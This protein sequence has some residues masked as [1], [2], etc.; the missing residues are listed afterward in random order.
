MQLYCSD[1]AAV[2]QVTAAHGGLYVW[3]PG[4]I[5]ALVV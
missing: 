5:L 2:L 1:I 3:L 4:T